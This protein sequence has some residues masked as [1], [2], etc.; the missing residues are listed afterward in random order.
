MVRSFRFVVG[1]SFSALLLACGG[2][3]PAPVTPPPTSAPVAAAPV[4]TA[5]PAA[6]PKLSAPI[7]EKTVAAATGVE[8]PESA[9]GI[10][11]VSFPRTDVPVAIDA[12][13]MPPF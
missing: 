5:A 1:A 9:D 6:A 13:K 12:W 4:V 7:D 2:S 8:K 10:V 3:A 11:K